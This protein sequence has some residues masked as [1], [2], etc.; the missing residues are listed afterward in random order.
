[1]TDWEQSDFQKKLMLYLLRSSDAMGDQCPEAESLIAYSEKILSG[2]K[3]E[4]IKAHLEG[5]PACS[6][7]D[8][9]L[10]RLEDVDALLPESEWQRVEKQLE[11]WFDSSLRIELA[12]SR[13]LNQK[14]RPNM[15]D[16]FA[17]WLRTREVRYALCASVVLILVAAGAS[18]FRVR[19]TPASPMVSVQ[20]R[21]IELPNVG[22]QPGAVLE[23]SPATSKNTLSIIPEGPS[24]Y[25]AALSD[26]ERHIPQRV[27]IKVGTEMTVRINS[28]TVMNPAGTVTYRCSLVQPFV[29]D[30]KVVL[31]A[32]STLVANGY[33]SKGDVILRIGE[34]LAIFVPSSSH[35]ETGIFRYF[36]NPSE[37]QPNV[38]AHVPEFPN[39]VETGDTIELRFITSSSYLPRG[40]N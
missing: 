18:L 5:C 30:G 11:N 25:Q 33:R 3:H 29:Q 13:Q 36:L 28:A 2:E 38:R 10:S 6:E 14:H 24:G 37:S 27:E 22:Q 35:P 26:S 31:P 19:K 1:M 40:S 32:K 20:E 39:G 8:R 21:K 16:R 17:A 34:I 23:A 12:S 15:M 7:T 9:L 4:L